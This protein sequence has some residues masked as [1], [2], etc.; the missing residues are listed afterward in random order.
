MTFW[1]KL[2]RLSNRAQDFF[3]LDSE[4]DCAALPGRL[5]NDVG[6][7]I[8]LIGLGAKLAKADGYVSRHE[9]LAFREVFQAHNETDAREV[10]RVF[11]LA[12]QTTIGYESYARQIARRYRACPALMEDLMDGLFHIAL[13]DGRVEDQE[14]VFLETVSE[15][16][17]FDEADFR[18]MKASHM[19]PEPDDPYV[20]LGI[21]Y[22][23]DDITVKKAYRRAAAEN[24]PD[25]LM[26]RGVP[27]ELSDLTAGKMAMINAAYAQIRTERRMN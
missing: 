3:A 14:L 24:H 27:E 16:F 19:G 22:K 10:K 17:G 9:E 2:S 11:D 12:R 5:K 23:A 4:C 20:V 25:T 21:D 6:F 7:A 8:A 1:T 18:R 13:A 15:I 26:A